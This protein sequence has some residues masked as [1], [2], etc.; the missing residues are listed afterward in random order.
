MMAVKPQE[1]DVVE[2]LCA[3]PEHNLQV[4]SRGAVVMDHT[5]YSEET[6]SAAYEVEFF[7]LQGITQ[8]V[9]TVCEE[10]LQVVSRSHC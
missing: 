7:D 1:Y 10:D 5:K 9:I 8:A 6:L 4:G 3:M 2:L